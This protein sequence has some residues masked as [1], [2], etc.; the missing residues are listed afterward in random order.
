M[1][2]RLIRLAASLLIVYALACG[3][4]FTFQ[5]SLMYFPG[6]PPPAPD[7][8]GLVGFSNLS[9][10]TPDGESLQLWWSA[11][12]EDGAPTLIYLHGNAGSL[13]NRAQR[14]HDVQQAGFGVAGLSWRGFGASTGTPTEEGLL[15]DAQAAYDWVRAQETDPRQI[16]L[17]GESLGT[18]P[19]VR[20][21][22]ENT[23]GALLLGAPYTATVDV[24]A[25]TYPIF[26]VRLLMHDQF[27]SRD[28]IAAVR[29]PIHIRHGEDDRVIP[30]AQ[31]RALAN[32][33]T[34]PLTFEAV[35]GGDHGVTVSRE[36]TAREIAFLRDV[37]A[38][39]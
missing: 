8:L 33:A 16:V 22:A 23:V 38:L 12:R 25:A 17:V 24:A 2:R 37:F 9:L 35:P 32:L 11:P 36:T 20:L 10:P 15:I 3:V 28:H 4:L 26:P 27:R 13:A 14:F 18:G 6:P 30:F 31:G 39:D 5:R 29:A 21:A 19:A 34:A 1:R 7:A